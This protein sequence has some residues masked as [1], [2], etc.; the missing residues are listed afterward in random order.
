M[1]DTGNSSVMLSRVAETDYPDKEAVIR[2][3]MNIEDVDRHSNFL[4]LDLIF[5]ISSSILFLALKKAGDSCKRTC[6]F[7]LWNRILKFSEING[8][9]SFGVFTGRCLQVHVSGFF[10]GFPVKPG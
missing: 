7:P 4:S 3:N 5:F 10:A 9:S 2:H 8:E 6:G 1:T